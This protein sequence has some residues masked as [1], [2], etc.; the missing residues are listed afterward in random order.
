MIIFGDVH[1]GNGR[2]KPLLNEKMFSAL[3]HMLTEIE[4]NRFELTPGTENTRF[5]AGDTFEYNTPLPS[6]YLKLLNIIAVKHKNSKWS[7][8][9][10]NHDSI[11]PD[12]FCAIEALVGYEVLLNKDTSVVNNEQNSSNL[13]AFVKPTEYRVGNSKIL[14]LPYFHEMFDYLRKYSGDCNILVSH[15]STYQSH[16]FA[17]IIDESDSVFDKFDAVIIGD[18]HNC[19]D[20]GKFHTT[21]ATFF[22]NV[23]E[24]NSETNIPSCIYI[25]ETADNPVSTIRR[26]E[27]PELKPPVITQLEDAEDENKIYILRTTENITHTH[28]VFVKQ[29]RETQAEELGEKENEDVLYDIDIN[30]VTVENLLDTIFPELDSAKMSKLKKFAVGQT[31]ALDLCDGSSDEETDI[32]IKEEE[33][34]T[35]SAEELLL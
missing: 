32:E 13:S 12:G 27:F 15:F 2:R 35:I 26:L 8:I 22:R 33:T 7:M 6:E 20:N 11:M 1:V 28:N 18:T 16:G 9:P 31:D 3:D 30:S 10:G 4:N 21:G 19:Y 24:M 17:G 23:D 25:D 5:I 14:L 34:E 29:I